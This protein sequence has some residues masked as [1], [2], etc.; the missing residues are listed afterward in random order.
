M[1]SWPIQ[2][3][4]RVVFIGVPQEKENTFR[5]HRKKPG[6]SVHFQFSRPS[7]YVTHF[8]FYIRNKE[9]GPM[10]LK[11]CTYAPLCNEALSE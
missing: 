6:K 8:H 11:Q 9:W 1:A 3:T 4:S 2:E 5:S 7:V 10:F